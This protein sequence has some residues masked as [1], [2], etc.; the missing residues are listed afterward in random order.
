MSAMALVQYPQITATAWAM[1]P[2]R[3]SVWGEFRQAGHG[4][5][6]LRPMRVF[7]IDCGTEIT[8]YGVV[9]N[10]DTGRQPRLVMKAMGAIRLVKSKTT[11]E[12]LAQVFH[13]LSAEL[14]R[15]KP[16]AV[17]IEEVFYS[18]NAK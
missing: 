8:G 1:R 7:G 10:D 16:D 17:A 2:G 18:V 12:R 14:E 6:T 5:G 9:E 11:A 13:E 15:W 4:C 3:R